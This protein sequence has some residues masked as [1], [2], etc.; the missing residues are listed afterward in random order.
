MKPR[1]FLFISLGLMALISIGYAA[2]HHEGEKDSAQFLEVYPHKANTKLDHCVLCHTGGE[3]EQKPGELVSLGS[4]Q[5]CHQV[6]GYDGSGNIIETLNPYGLDYLIHGRNA[7]A[8]RTINPLDSDGDGFSNEVEIEAGRYPGD[9][10]DDPTKIVAPYK[11]Y[12]RDQLEAMDAHTQFL[13]LNTARSGDFYAE[14]TGVVL[15]NLLNDAGMLDS[16]TGVTVFAPDGWSNYHPLDESDDPSLYHVRGEYPSA[17]F[18]YHEEADVLL[19]PVD[20]WCDYSAPSVTGRNHLDPIWNPDGLK[21]ILAY[22]RDGASLNPGVLNVDNK[23]DGEGPFRVVPPQ[24]TP[25]PPDQSSRAA[26][27]S[28]IWPYD[29]DWDHNAGSSSRTVTFI[30]VEPLP[31]GYT[32]VDILEAGWDYADKDQVVIYGALSVNVPDGIWKDAPVGAPSVNMNF[33]IQTYSTSS[34]LVIASPDGDTCYAFLDD[35]F[36]NGVDAP[37]QGN[38]GHR[39]KMNFTGQGIASAELTLSGQDPVSYTLHSWYAAS[40]SEDGN[41]LWKDA[42]QGSPSTFSIYRQTYDTSSM[43]IA[44]PDA[45]AFLA[46]LNPDKNYTGEVP[47]LSGAASL[48]CSFPSQDSGSARLTYAGQDPQDLTLTRWFKAPYPAP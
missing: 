2:Y 28:V 26:N 4:C 13:L 41:G 8:V 36:N 5:W 38:Q 43:M 14:Y 24:K 45:R 25:S 40:S 12:S 16:A 6:Y 27:Q 32:D 17:V 3:Y 33:Y 37:D 20:G 1:L 46:F 42:E 23:L 31:E 35:D 9:A 29:Y 10:Q 21:M 48:A 15:E 11:V 18:Y 19:N 30:R 47:S 7:Q 34:V 22:K 39:L 44:S